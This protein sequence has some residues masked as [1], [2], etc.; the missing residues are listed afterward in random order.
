MKGLEVSLQDEQLKAKQL[1]TAMEEIQF[2]NEEL[3]VIK[4]A[5]EL[6]VRAL[7]SF[8]RFLFLSPADP[9]RG[10]DREEDDYWR[11]LSFRYA[12]VR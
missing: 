12:A 5:M 9:S 1:R 8:V 3:T 6:Q 4:I 11:W 7:D 2:C 10:D